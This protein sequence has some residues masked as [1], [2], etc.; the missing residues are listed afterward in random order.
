[1]GRKRHLKYRIYYSHSFEKEQR[2]LQEN[3]ILEPHAETECRLKYDNQEG[4]EIRLPDLNEFPEPMSTNN[5]R[6]SAI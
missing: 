4:H 2:D 6:A 1:M 3:K 5:G